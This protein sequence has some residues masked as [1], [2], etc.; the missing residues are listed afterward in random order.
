MI[1][2]LEWYK[3]FYITAQAGSF[4]RAAEQLFITQPAVTHT[5]KQL[6]AK[7]KG[8]LF[9]RTSRGVQLT[10][11]GQILFQ[12]IEQAYN[13]ISM[14]EKKLA[15]M[16]NLMEGEVRIGA[17]DTLCKHY[18]LPQLE[19]FHRLYPGIKLQITNRT[20]TETI[21][22]LKAGKIDFGI[23]NLP[24][25]DEQLIIR[26]SIEIQ[27]CF[28]AGAPYKHLAASK[29]TLQQL[30]EHP[31]LLLEKGSNTRSFID[32]YAKQQDVVIQPDIE[33]GSIDLLVEFART[34]LGVACVIRNFVM[35]ELEQSALYEI[36]L[37]PPI[38]PRRVG[39]VT[40]KNV[41]GSVATGRF[42]EML[43]VLELVAPD[44]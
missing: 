44:R 42:I 4:S 12:Y 11:E 40:L 38:P 30:S 23:V 15:E 24:I 35:S 3:V 41:P 43:T 1:E 34:G 20:T 22:L 5:I 37:E 33:L 17:G 29:I 39:I 32:Q 16:H 14:G 36:Q 26:D 8:Q 21:Q 6:E 9:F 2:N 19:V 27:D 25:N 31:I 10:N 7:H 18:L 28:I 13:L